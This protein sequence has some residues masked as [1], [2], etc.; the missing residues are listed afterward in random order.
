[1]RNAVFVVLGLA[2]AASMYVHAFTEEEI[3]KYND[4]SYELLHNDRAVTAVYEGDLLELERG[5][6][7]FNLA[8]LDAGE[9]RLLRNMIFAQYGY[10]FKSADLQ[11][12]FDQFS[13]YEPQYDDVDHMLDMI[14]TININRIK[15]FEG[16]HTKHEDIN[17]TVDDLVG[18]W[19][20]SPVVA[21]GYNDLM[22]FFPDMAFRYF[23]NQ[24]DWSQRLSGMYG[25]WEMDYNRLTLYIGTM[26]VM[27]GGEIVEPTASCASEFAIEGARDDAMAF[28]PP[29]EWIFPITNIITEKYD[30]YPEADMER[31]TIGGYT[32][33]KIS[34]DPYMELN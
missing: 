27:V 20:A 16:A 18:I 34:A 8:V 6:S 17:V 21:A 25:F 19:H 31:I 10:R 24:M 14:D 28:E 5:F 2:L 11:D 13:W 32:W 33:W 29:Q 12:W 30:P 4:H 1:M 9:L 15:L 7:D 22:Y 23:P 26:T 3:D